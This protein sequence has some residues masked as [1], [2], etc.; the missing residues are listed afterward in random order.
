MEGGESVGGRSCLA[1]KVH[2][3][4]GSLSKSALRICLSKSQR[5]SEST[6][7]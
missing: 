4:D 1:V 2:S 5:S 3:E 6:P 7:V